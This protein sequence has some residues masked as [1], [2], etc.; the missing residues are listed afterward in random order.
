MHVVIV[1][2]GQVGSHV[3]RIMVDEGHEVAVVELNEPLARTL[4]ARL[5]ALVLQGSGV[6]AAVLRRAGIE[7]ADL[8]L[9]VTGV[10]EVNL[11]TCMTARKYG[12]P[13]L[14]V[15]ARVRQSRL[16]DGESLSAADLGLDA[17]MS[18]EQAIA[19]A[20]V[21]TLRF[22]GSGE[23]HEL[24]DG[25]LVLV[26]MDLT[27]ESPIVHDTLEAVRAE[28]P[29][30]SMVIAVQG[31]AGFRI[32][33]P[34][35]RLHVDERA[36]VLTSPRHVTELAILSGVPWYHA[37]RLLIV[38]CGNT[39]L[40]VARLL[41]QQS[42]LTI[43]IIEKDLRRAE[44]VAGLLPRSLVLNGD[45]SDPEFMQRQIEAGDIDA[46]LVLLKDS[47]KSVLGGIFASFLGARK[48]IVRCD[49]PAYA[50]LA[51]RLG[52]DALL[53]PKQAM[54]DAIL[55][56][57]RRGRV[58]ST[59]VLGVHDIEFTEFTVPDQPRGASLIG[60]A[61]RDLQIPDGALL[62]AVM[63][64]DDVRMAASDMVLRAGDRLLFACQHAALADIEALLS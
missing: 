47:E 23:L 26:G 5:D 60:T 11:V 50:H 49:K 4:D 57:L 54:T 53:G 30:Q 35:D 1:G 48:V 34:S 19:Q 46:V 6:S 31:Q 21:E 42:A 28:L 22:P 10:D 3:A 52:I 51:T 32:P 56:W 64:D 24:A 36:F 43:T 45:G 55:R 33:G 25:K 37:K 7:R 41:E 39:G 59:M 58:K 29:E 61:V 40:A 63:R 15:L 20:I 8:L 14:R 13:Q 18:P 62:A 27:S 9:A 2:A 12:G 17:L 38:G 16:A 44:L